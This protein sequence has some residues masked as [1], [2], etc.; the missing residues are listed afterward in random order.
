[1]VFQ[2]TCPVSYTHLNVSSAV[3][4]YF[5]DQELVAVVIGLILAIAT[6]AVIFGGVHRIGIISSTVVPIMALL[7]II[8][9]L[10]ITLANVQKLPAIFGMIMEQ[11]F[12]LKAI[13]GGFAGS[14]VMYGIKRGL[15]SNEAGMGSAPNALSLIHI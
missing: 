11:A 14:C 12:D 15:F 8:L 2:V 3:S 10:Y 13:M 5:E 4:Y 1:M 7:Y 6:A 9:G